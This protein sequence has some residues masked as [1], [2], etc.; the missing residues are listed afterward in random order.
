MIVGFDQT[1]RGVLSESSVLISEE[2]GEAWDL[3]IPWAG[4]AIV[5]S[6]SEVDGLPNHRTSIWWF[7]ARHDINPQMDGLYGKIPPRN[8]WWLGVPPWHPYG[9]HQL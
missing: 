2:A 8:R 5:P 9:N 3:G 1:Q 6:P 4:K 7:P